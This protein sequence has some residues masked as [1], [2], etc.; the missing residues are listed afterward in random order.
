M[1]IILNDRTHALRPLV[2]SRLQSRRKEGLWI[3]ISSNSIAGK[4]TVRRWAKRR[5]QEAFREELNARGL[6]MN[7]MGMD[8][9]G[10]VVN[11]TM[12]VNVRQPSVQAEW[13]RVKARV[14]RVVDYVIRTGGVAE[15][16]N[17]KSGRIGAGP[18]NMAGHF[19]RSFTQ[20]N[21]AA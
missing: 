11:G 3:R 13:K 14:S 6:N 21:D 8:R 5:V 20:E 1:Q 7:G 12:E 10:K 17:E 2:L 15:E 4:A 18:H 19:P 9:Q 16:G